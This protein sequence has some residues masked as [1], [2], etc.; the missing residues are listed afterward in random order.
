MNI[1]KLIDFVVTFLIFLVFQYFALSWLYFP[2]LS[3]DEGYY[4]MGARRI[5]EGD[6]FLQKHSF[7]KPFL[8]PL[9]VALSGTIFGDSYLGFRFLGWIF[10]SVSFWLFYLALN[11]FIQKNSLIETK[12]ILLMKWSLIVGLFLNPLLISNSAS[13]MGEPFLLF[14][15]MV[16]LYNYPFKYFS[17]DNKGFLNGF[18]GSFWIKGSVLIW[19]P[20]FL[21]IP[22][23]S[24][25]REILKKWKKL[26]WPAAL[27]F[28]VGLW[29][30]IV[31]KTKLFVFRYLLD[32]LF[33]TEGS[34]K[35]KNSAGKQFLSWLEIIK[36]DLGWGFLVLLGILVLFS[37]L[38]FNQ[39]KKKDFNQIIVRNLLAFW[40][41]VVLFFV[42][43]T[44]TKVGLMPRYLISITP[45]VFFFCLVLFGLIQISNF[46]SGS[47]KINRFFVGIVTICCFTL[48][49]GLKA[50]Q[51]PVFQG[52]A[53]LSPSIMSEVPKEATLIDKLIWPVGAYIPNDLQ[54]IEVPYDVRLNR[55]KGNFDFESAVFA[56]DNDSLFEAIQ[57]YSELKGEYCPEIIK[58]PE[59]NITISVS[60]FKQVFLKSLLAENKMEWTEFNLEKKNFVEP[61]EF[62]KTFNMN[63]KE[64]HAGVRFSGRLKMKD[65]VFDDY[66]ELVVQGVFVL[67]RGRSLESLWQS[68]DVWSLSMRLEEFAWPKRAL[69]LTPLVLILK[70][71]LTLPI[72]PLI[73]EDQNYRPLMI[74]L[75]KD[76]NGEVILN[77]EVIK[78]LKKCSKALFKI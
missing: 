66:P 18:A 70:K 2:E 29:Y 52:N 6:W 11:R 24:D 58:L 7:D 17:D 25:L 13:S 75:K 15:L 31:G 78:N 30:G 37:A 41:T 77:V 63:F 28:A 39:L 42:V 76:Q 36:N 4:I 3:Y 45:L 38:V 34:Y 69:D 49:L 43:V 14:F 48:P 67:H 53:K 71:G 46:S 54:V 55:H 20:L 72:M 33:S 26:L 64:S 51:P 12:S 10:L 21:L 5:L 59:S 19:L 73:M 47:D 16:I 62:L 23:V 32:V 60:Y 40:L 44:F 74:N 1:R 56:Y 68:K 27:L 22:K 9:L 57:I 50:W 35:E 8:H 65:L 61:S